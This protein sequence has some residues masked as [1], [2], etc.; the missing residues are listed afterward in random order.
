MSSLIKL[1]TTITGK[2]FKHMGLVVHDIDMMRDSRALS[3]SSAP[4]VISGQRTR[5][6][7]AVPLY[8][9]FRRHALVFHPAV[10]EPAFSMPMKQSR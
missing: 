3:V 1:Q 4:L 5:P 6:I 7:R 10:P 8:E 2:W 9:F